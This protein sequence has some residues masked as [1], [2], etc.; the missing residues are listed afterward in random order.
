[1]IIIYNE[2]TSI[3]KKQL[4]FLKEVYQDIRYIYIKQDLLEIINQKKIKLILIDGI[5]FAN[6]FKELN[7]YKNISFLI[8]PPYSNRFYFEN[9]E[10]NIIKK[11]N[12]Y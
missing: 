1:M 12:P 6:I 2:N 9:K 11:K 4:R 5:S 8:F 7:A 10:I 3:G